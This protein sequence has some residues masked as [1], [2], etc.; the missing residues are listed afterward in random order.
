MAFIEQY[1]L[2]WLFGCFIGY[3][4]HHYL[5]KNKN[6]DIHSGMAT[7][8]DEFSIQGIFFNIQ[9]GEG[10]VFFTVLWS[11]VCAFLFCLAFAKK[12]GSIFL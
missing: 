10:A 8:S 2:V 9:S 4:I 6:Q 3:G 5:A 7:R 12:I 11:I 1:W